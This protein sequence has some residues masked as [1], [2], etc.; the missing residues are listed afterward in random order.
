MS[1]QYSSY[2]ASQLLAS[3]VMASLSA[4]GERPPP[5]KTQHGPNNSGDLKQ[6]QETIDLKVCWAFTRESERSIP[7]V[8][9]YEDAESDV[10]PDC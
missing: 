2:G 3:N 9:V 1:L 6:C 5:R 10:A 7:A 8:A 4:R